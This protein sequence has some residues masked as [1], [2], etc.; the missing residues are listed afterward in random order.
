MLIAV[1]SMA[2]FITLSFT[3]GLNNLVVSMF[4][5]LDP[6]LK[7][8]PK[9][10]KV[11]NYNDSI[12]NILLENN[13][14]NY[15]LALEEDVLIK[16]GDKQLI[17]RI[18]GV[19]DNYT[20][21]SK[22]DSAIISNEYQTKK[23]DISMA[24]V[25][26]GVAYQLG[27]IMG[28]YTPIQIF[29]PRRGIKNSINPED[30]YNKNYCHPAGVFSI[31][32]DIDSKY[33]I[34][35]LQFVR[36]LL[37]YTNEVSAIEIKLSR[38]VDLD[39]VEKQLQKDLGDNY[40]IQNKFEQHE[41]LYKVMKS[42]KWIVFMIISLICVIA[43]FSSIGTLTMVIIDK[44]HDITILQSMGVSLARIKSIFLI[45]SWLTS[46][47]G[48]V[49]GISIGLILCVLQEKFGLLK[50]SSSGNFVVDAY[51]VAVEAM[52]IFLC[53]GIVVI[54]GFIASYIPV[55]KITSEN[56]KI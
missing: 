26:Q 18:K 37:Q 8:I 11:F 21:V 9:D 33:L 43:S 55:R 15:S 20:K 3:N 50:L 36:S 30:A 56:I 44:K 19:D 22:I 6:D 17:G 12:A 5:V 24:V 46:I 7:V 29:A 10:G 39:K 28:Y 25:G 27:I 16:Y 42:E 1:V 34:T 41:F 52:D 2:L 23:G 4:N 35:N 32:Q 40:L 45:Q 13:I 47:I 38:N 51:P 31:Q 53:L 49:A 48:S 54:I 14:S